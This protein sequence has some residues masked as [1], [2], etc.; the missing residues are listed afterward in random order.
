MAPSSKKHYLFLSDVKVK[1]SDQEIPLLKMPVSSF[2][3]QN[4]PNTYPSL[5]SLM[6]QLVKNLPAIWETWVRSLGW[7]D[8]LEKGRVT[9]SS[10][11]DWRIPWTV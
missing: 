6:I 9:H 3:N 10:I 11:L 4:Y 1:E 2:C 7:E 8:P 5:A